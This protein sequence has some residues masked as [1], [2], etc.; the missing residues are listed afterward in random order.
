MMQRCRIG[1]YKSSAME[2]GAMARQA[3]RRKPGAK[4][5][6]AW[7]ETTSAP[8]QSADES[9]AGVPRITTTGETDLASIRT[10]RARKRIVRRPATDAERHAASVMGEALA[11]G[12]RAAVEAAIQEA[13][14]E[15]F[16][17]PARV[18]GG[19]VEIRPSGEM[20]P[21]DDNAPWSP[22]DWRKAATR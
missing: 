19:A 18:D 14:A 10:A 6:E 16:A 2:T 12:F 22:V 4:R 11:S 7:P 15:G 9:T 20:V 3:A 1:L 13:H 5:D 8:G 17:I 21:I